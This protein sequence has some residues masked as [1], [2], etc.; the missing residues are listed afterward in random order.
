MSCAVTIDHAAAARLVR[1]QQEQDERAER[2]ELYQLPRIQA[3]ISAA[4]ARDLAKSRTEKP[5]PEGSIKYDAASDRY[6]FLNE[7]DS[8]DLAPT[9][10]IFDEKR[11]AERVKF[12][13]AEADF[14]A[15]CLE[16]TGVEFSPE[17]IDRQRA[18]RSEI[19]EQSHRLAAMLEIAGTPAYRN[20]DFQLWIWHV[21][22]QI[23][24][25]IP[26][27]RRICF[28]PY[29][30]ALVRSSKLAALEFFLQQNPFCRFWTFT[31]G[32]RVNI[33]GLRAR[34]E[35]LH[36][37]LNA[38]NK[39]LKRRFGI[40]LVFRSTELGTVE[41]LKTA[42]AVRK[43]RAA[44]AAKKRANKG[45]VI[46]FTRAE[47]KQFKDDSGEIELDQNGEPLFHPHAHCV[48]YM[49][50]GPLSPK[51]WDEAI[52]FVWSHWGD[53]WDAG[54]IVS[55]AREACKYVTK[56]GDM[57]KLSPDHL[58][59]VENALHGLRLVVPLGLLKK[60]IAARRTAGECLRR[61]KTHDGTIW[62]VA[63]DHNKHAE[64]DAADRDAAFE[65]HQSESADR[66]DARGADGVTTPIRFGH[67]GNT[68]REHGQSL[69]CKVLARLCPA[70][71]PKGLTEPRVIIGGSYLDRRTI[72][73]HPLVSRLW[74]QTVEAWESG[75]CIR[76]HTGTPTGESVP[77]DFW[78]DLPERMEP[79][80][81]PVWD[82]PETAE[83]CLN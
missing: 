70:V 79:H 1:Y 62:R 53:H 73:N 6:R 75:L 50:N 39:E 26:N 22:S 24:E 58:A 64:L 81:N 51:K 14:A 40:Q 12:A 17:E 69:P 7:G 11:H 10:S 46:A 83:I 27:F 29:I 63:L 82:V 37:R 47:L 3:H 32:A 5:A 41:T 18:E 19:R 8:S 21:H 34:V 72:N 74:S 60:E 66:I 80:E 77:F 57:L 52:S 49:P 4:L 42:G 54:K 38:L 33:A 71:G 35:S 44:I 43:K 65:L 68:A 9:D 36:E 30:A 31:S 59:G 28:L 16:N 23:A 15:V 61:Q 20:D 25:K 56:P 76:V 67:T 48:L 2:R 45:G 55:N 13:E 78:D